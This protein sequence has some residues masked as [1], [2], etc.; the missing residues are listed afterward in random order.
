MWG[1]LNFKFFS[2]GPQLFPIWFHN[3]WGPN[4]IFDILQLKLAVSHKHKSGIT[5]KTD[6]SLDN[7]QKNADLSETI[8]NFFEICFNLPFKEVVS[9]STV[10]PGSLKTDPHPFFGRDRF[11]WPSWSKF[12]LESSITLDGWLL[13]L[14]RVVRLGSKTWHRNVPAFEREKKDF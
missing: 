1:S 6:R 2:Q 11:F 10:P 9:K 5:L 3:W 7:R 12:D 14:L 4:L 13:Y 8:R